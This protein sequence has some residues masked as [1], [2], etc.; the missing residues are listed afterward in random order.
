[1]T[2]AR[3]ELTYEGPRFRALRDNLA[4]P[5]GL[6]VSTGAF[7]TSRFKQAFKAQ[8]RP[9]GSWRKRSVPNVA[10]IL[11]DFHEGRQAPVAD[12]FRDSPVL[13]DRGDLARSIAPEITGVNEVAVGSKLDYAAVHNLGGEAETLPMTADFQAWLGKWIA[14]PAGTPWGAKLR[15]MT[16]PFWT[17]KSTSIDVPPRPFAIVTRDDVVDLASLVEVDLLS[18]LPAGGA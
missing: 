10:G 15:W 13:Q 8:G 9:P 5:R 16:L 6:L 17:G 3:L 12:R 1:M 2:T 7:L 18:A 11:R 4:R 14:T